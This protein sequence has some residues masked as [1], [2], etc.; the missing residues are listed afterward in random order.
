MADNNLKQTISEDMK[1]AMKSGDKL[2]LSVLR[3]LNSELKNREIE[4]GEE[5]SDE[6]VLEVV[7]KQAKKRKDS[8]AAYNQGG[9]SELAE[10]EQLELDILNKYLPEQMGEEELRRVISE[11]I[12]ETGAKE[13]SEM[14]KV[15][16]ALMPKIKGKA[17]N[18]L[19]SKIVKEELDK[20]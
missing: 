11:T 12:N 2:A 1:S 10:Q 14:G 15:M 18:S 6:A 9:R 7:S 5:L 3:M 17:D 20:I 4:K 16:G 8:I 13:A 19:A